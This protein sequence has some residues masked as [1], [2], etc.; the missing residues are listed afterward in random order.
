MALK[1]LPPHIDIERAQTQ[2]GVNRTVL[3]YIYN[4]FEDKPDFT[5]LD[6]PCGNAEFLTCLKQLFPASSLTGGDMLTPSKTDHINFYQMDL[7]EDFPFANDARFDMVTSISGVMMFSNT[8]RFL[9]NCTYHL[10]PG[11]TFILTNDNSSNIKDRLA[12]LILGR[13]RLFNLVFEDDQPMTENVPINELVRIIRNH[14]IEIED[15]LYTSLY[16]KDWIYAPIAAIVY[17]TQYLYLK[18][19]KTRIPEALKW[20]MYPFKHLLCRH[21]IIYGK[22]R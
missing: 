13:Y 18:R 8:L 14:D 7:T 5:A 19:M 22:K 10:K 4:K 21:Y 17:A 3:T 16:K 9:K 6:L 11:G 1:P 12:F 15:I 20:K 2:L